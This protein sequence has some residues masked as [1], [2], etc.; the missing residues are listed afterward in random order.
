MDLVNEKKEEKKVRIK[1]I[2]LEMLGTI[3]GSFIMALGVSLFLLPNQLSSGGVAGIATITYYLLNIPMGTMILLINIPLFLISIFKIGKYFFIKTLIGTASLS[4]F[5]D[6]LDKFEP[7][8]EDRFLACVYGGIILG[9]GTAIL[10]K[11]NSS[12]GGSDLVSYLAKKYKPTAQAGNII[13][14]IDIVIVTLNMIF[15]KEIEIGLYSAIAIYLMGKMIDILFEGIDF[16]K[17]MIIISDKNEEIAKAILEKIE[18]GS[19]GLYGKGMYTNKEKLVLI[20]AAYRNDVSKIK[21]IARKID[22]RSFI[23]ITNSR[24]VVGQGFE[25]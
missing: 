21:M 12:T 20:C 15:F 8:T 10:L 4:L 1:K 5:I 19:T 9:I 17:L 22:P 2:I 13:V 7:L 25:K 3:L 18:R 23:V 6:I 24:E 16:T 11:A 14:I